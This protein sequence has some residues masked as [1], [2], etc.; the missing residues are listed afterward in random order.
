MSSTT[1]VLT[2]FFDISHSFKTA[3]VQSFEKNPNNDHRKKIQGVSE[4]LWPAVKLVFIRFLIYRAVLKRRPF[5][6]TIF[7]KSCS[8]KVIQNSR[9]KYSLEIAAV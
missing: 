9:G 3:A 7:L 4:S 2:I 6:K 8:R 1:F 5:R